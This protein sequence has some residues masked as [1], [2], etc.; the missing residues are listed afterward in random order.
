[1]KENLFS[2]VAYNVKY[3]MLYLYGRKEKKNTDFL[4]AKSVL[5]F[6]VV[7]NNLI[8]ADHNIVTNK[9][10]ISSQRLVL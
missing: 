4:P 6:N 3:V 1:M 7:D 2:F 8:C 5:T 10:K 9:V